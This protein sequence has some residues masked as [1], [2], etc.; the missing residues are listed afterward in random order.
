LAHYD[1]LCALV[2]VH[3]IPATI[4]RP[5]TCESLI[6]AAVKAA[7]KSFLPSVH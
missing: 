6:I 5:G 4:A 3:V 1:P 7:I 2:Q